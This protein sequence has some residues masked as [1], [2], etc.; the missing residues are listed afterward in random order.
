MS[1]RVLVASWSPSE[2]EGLIDIAHKLTGAG[3]SIAVLA[4]PQGDSPRG[5]IEALYSIANPPFDAGRADHGAAALAAAAQDFRASLVLTGP[6][7]L[8]REAIARAGFV[9]SAPSVT[10][11]RDPR[12]EAEVVEWSRDLLSGN[13][14][15]TE[16]VS[17][18][19]VLLSLAAVPA[20]G[21]NELLSVGTP[22]HRPLSIELP[23]Y[24]FR[25]LSIQPKPTGGTDLEAADRIVSV[26][27][28]LRKKDDLILIETLAR[29]L[30]AV[31]GCTRPIA[32]ESGWLSDDHWVGLTGHRVRP[33]L[34]L[35]IGISGAAQ[36]LVGMRDSRV[37]VAINSDANAP[38]FQQADYQVVG[39]LYAIVPELSRR[40][41]ADPTAPS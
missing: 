23:T 21:E 25:R 19:P 38:I 9:L 7:K 13:A 24:H 14:T 15:S 37:V 16:R 26:G 30:G 3:G 33:A 1:E 5:A 22:E 17:V 11:A 41:A 36:H 29:E 39:D 28:G 35:A 18:R 20:S 27:R 40:L 4:F 6:S 32:A 8:E 10:G 34:Y 2:T 12:V 31:I